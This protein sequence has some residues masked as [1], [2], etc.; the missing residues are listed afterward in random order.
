MLVIINSVILGSKINKLGIIL[1][2]ISITFTLLR[3]ISEESDGRF[4]PKIKH[5]H[6]N[7]NYS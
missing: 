2:A 1:K 5:N 7:Y 4:G 3:L 6:L